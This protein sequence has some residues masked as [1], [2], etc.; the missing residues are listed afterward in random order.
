[1]SW[2][3][4]LI[5]LGFENAPR[6]YKRFNRPYPEVRS[7]RDV[8]SRMLD[9]LQDSMR[10]HIP[11]RPSCRHRRRASGTIHESRFRRRFV[12]HGPAVSGIHRS[13]QHDYEVSAEELDFLVDT[14]S[15]FSGV[16]GARMTGG[17][18]GG[19]TVNL[20]APDRVE[21]F[22]SHISEAYRRAFSKEPTIY[23]CQPAAGAG[24]VV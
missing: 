21:A 11:P 24:E 3:T 1:M 4:P 6:R 12:A 10:P 15:G 23:R 14:A 8:S 13:L 5:R 2:A 17:G 22:E 9:T 16:F 7:L 18:F 19:C 20:I